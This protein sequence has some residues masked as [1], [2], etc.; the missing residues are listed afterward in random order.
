MA[1]LP[2]P[3]LRKFRP[4][5]SES[6]RTEVMA[7]TEM[8][9]GRRYIAASLADKLIRGEAVELPQVLGL[10]EEG[11]AGLLL[12]CGIENAGID[13]HEVRRERT[14]GEC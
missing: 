1:T 14:D 10:D 5:A 13:A 3:F 11:Y 6:E 9:S 2:L 12:M 8:G 7:V 4:D